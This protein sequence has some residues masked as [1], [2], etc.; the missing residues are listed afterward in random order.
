[1]NR[2]TLTQTGELWGKSLIVDSYPMKLLRNEVV[3]ESIGGKKVNIL[4]FGG[5]FQYADKPN[6]NGRV[7]PFNVLKEAVSAIQE[8]V[9]SRAVMGELDHPSDA[10]LHLD[11]ISHVVTKL[12]MEGK[13]VFGECE[14]LAETTCGRQLKSLLNSGVRIG[15]SSRGVGDM[16]TTMREG[17]ELYT[18]LPGFMLVTWDI[19]GTPSVAGS[20]MSIKESVEKQKNKI[21]DVKKM[22]ER[23][24]L[25]EIKKLFIK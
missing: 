22:N 20:Y 13:E 7:Y 8:D 24:I 11:R 14:V 19:V 10:K 1:M 2:G 25:E 4:K 17:K 5:R 9:K 16:E 15:I 18:V 23:A 3:S 6:E 12:W 21:I